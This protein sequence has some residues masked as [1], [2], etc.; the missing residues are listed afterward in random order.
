MAAA[1]IENLQVT[2][3]ASYSRNDT[4]LVTISEWC[5]GAIEEADVFIINIEI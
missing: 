5:F 2:L 3:A 4:N 1:V